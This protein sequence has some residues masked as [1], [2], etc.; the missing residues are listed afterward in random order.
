MMAA[1]THGKLV[2]LF[3]DLL[4]TIRRVASGPIK[5]Q[6]KIRPRLCTHVNAVEQGEQACISMESILVF[7]IEAT[8]CCWRAR[9][10]ARWDRCVVRI[11]G[12]ASRSHTLPLLTRATKSPRRR[13]LVRT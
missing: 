10:G 9:S 11:R 8:F 12:D 6:M 7:R 3:R 1:E 2:E 13:T 5:Y 4:P